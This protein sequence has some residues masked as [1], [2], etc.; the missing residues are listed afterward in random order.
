LKVIL[1]AL[2]EQMRTSGA[3]DLILTAG[4]IPQLRVNGLLRPSGTGVLRGE[5]T[6][7]MAE[8]LMNPRQKELFHEVKNMDLSK[9]LPGDMRCRINIYMQKD[10][11]AIAIRNIPSTIPSFEVL[12][13]PEIVRDFA[14]QPHGLVLITGPA[15]SG[16]STTLAAMIDFINQTRHVHVVCL[17]DP[18]EYVHAHHKSVIDQREIGADARSF[19]EALRGVFRQSPDVIMVGEMR[20]LETIQLVLTLAETGHLI[21]A[22]LHTQDTSHAINRMVDIFPAGQ[23]EQIYMQLSLVLI[24]VI[25]QQLIITTDRQRRVLAYEV[26]RVTHAVR[27]LIRERQIQQ[28][29]SVVETSR[30]EG[31]VTMNETLRSLHEQKLIEFDEALSRS[32]RPKEFVRAVTRSGNGS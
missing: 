17:E 7:A 19:Q 13:L 16:K 15:G 22:T 28:I 14:L 30:N 20:D 23:Q 31:M 18:I 2:I 27:N 26:L 3:S 12:G 9:E 4:A 1:E 6:R 21:L 8:H 24:G 25:S 32:P 10:A 11:H 29:Y 5:D